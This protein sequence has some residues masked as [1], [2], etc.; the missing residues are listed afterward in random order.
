MNEPV[1]LVTGGAGNV[2]RA[3]TRA[4]LES[5]A[6]VT[7]PFYKTDAP[8]TLDELRAEFGD[9]V[10]SFALDLTTE[11]GAQRAIQE[12]VEWGGRLDVVAHLVGGYTGGVRLAD[13]PVE[14]LDHMLDLNLKSAWLVSRFAIPAM[15]RVGGGAM[16]FVSSR[17][18]VRG[19]AKQ[20]TYAIAKSALVTLVEAIA[21]EYRD[22]G[23]RANVVLPGTVDTESNRHKMPDADHGRWT[24]PREI[25]EV[26]RYLASPEARAINGA[27]VPVYG[28]S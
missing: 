26:I 14:A 16:V 21:E 10:H 1:V 18:A 3:V 11:R 13:T 24:S 6:R 28:I 23:I 9:R 4:F 20:A 19:R 27:S 2:G 12:V 17:A 5:G 22:E 15:L 7:V 8:A 25:A